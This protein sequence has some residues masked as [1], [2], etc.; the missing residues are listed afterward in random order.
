MRVHTIT[1]QWSKDAAAAICTQPSKENMLRQGN[2]AS[3]RCCRIIH[4][5]QGQACNNEQL[6][7]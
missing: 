6:S 2:I 5:D 1:K 4:S 7:C 3:K